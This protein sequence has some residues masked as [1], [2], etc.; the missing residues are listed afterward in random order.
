MRRKNLHKPSPIVGTVQCNCLSIPTP[1]STRSNGDAISHSRES[2]LE[3]AG[4]AISVGVFVGDPVG[5]VPTREKPKK[6]ADDA[7]DEAE[8]R[9]P[10]EEAVGGGEGGGE[11]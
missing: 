1:Y 5:E 10:G 4:P 11:V 3:L 6:R 9:L 2:H 8:A 7:G